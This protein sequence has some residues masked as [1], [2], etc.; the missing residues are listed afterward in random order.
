MF[1]LDRVSVISL[2]LTC[3]QLTV[4]NIHVCLLAPTEYFFLFK[5]SLNIVSDIL[6]V[7]YTAAVLGIPTDGVACFCHCRCLVS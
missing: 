4:R 6:L 3:L 1:I 7:A 5:A 2:L